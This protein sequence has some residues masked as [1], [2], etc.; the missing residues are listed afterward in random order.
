MSNIASIVTRP[1]NLQTDGWVL[2]VATLAIGTFAIGTDSFVLAG[3]LPEIAQAFR[4][5]PGTAGLTVTAFAMTY[6][7]AAPI[8]A[9]VLGRAAR[10]TLLLWGLAAFVA[11]N[12]GAAAAPNFGLLLVARVLT[13][14]AAAMFTPTASAAAAALGGTA[15]RGTALSIILGGLTVGT[16]FGVPLGTGIGQRL[17]WQASLLFVAAVGV[18]AALALLLTLR[19]LPLPAATSLR[20]RLAL[21][22]N[23]QVMLA[24]SVNAAS[25]CGGIMVYTYVAEVIGQTAGIVG[26][27]L[28]LALFIW[29]AGGSVGTFLSGWLSDHI[30]PNPTIIIM[31]LALI[32]SL[33][34]LGFST[35]PAIAILLL[36]LF[37]A[38]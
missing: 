18:L 38:G 21:F 9:T 27:T 12:L 29:G 37:S 19:P 16:V 10:K 4:I 2:P 17:G 11:A 31:L 1:L 32:L 26:T 25:V 20:Q 14:I 33:L 13:G 15:R 8:L 3:I 24:A 5:S 35:V 22:A 30:G 23:A 34:A 28:T 36:A 6:A 7:V